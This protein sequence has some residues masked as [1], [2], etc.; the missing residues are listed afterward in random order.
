MNEP[1]FGKQKSSD[2]DESTEKKAEQDANQPT[3]DFW[4]EE[5]HKPDPTAA[6]TASPSTLP[7]SDALIKP[8]ENKTEETLTTE[9]TTTPDPAVAP[10]TQSP[11]TPPPFA[12]ETVTTAQSMPPT[13]EEIDPATPTQTETNEPNVRKIASATFRRLDE[14]LDMK[15]VEATSSIDTAPVEP[16]K[17]ETVT[18]AKHPEPMVN[19]ETPPIPT[20]TAEPVEPPT[21]ML[22]DSPIIQDEA[23][24]AETVIE[25]SAPTTKEIPMVEAT[26]EPPAPVAEEAAT[27]DV[28]IEVDELEDD[29]I[30]ADIYDSLGEETTESSPEEMGEVGMPD[31]QAGE[32]AGTTS[33]HVDVDPALVQSLIA[34]HQQ[35]LDTAGAQGRRAVFRDNLTGMDFSQQRLSG[36]SF[37]GLDLSRCKFTQALLNEV[38]FGD[39]IL[40]GADFTTANLDSATLT[41]VNANN[42][43]FSAAQM[44]KAD[45]GNAQLEQTNFT[46]AKMTEANMRD[47]NLSK[48]SLQNVTANLV[49]FRG[50]HL[51][52]ADLSEGDFSQASFREANMNDS[53]L[54]SAILI[55]TSF[56]DTE[57]M[58]VDLNSADFSQAQ[59]ISSEVQAQFMQM[60]RSKL[61]EESQ[62]LERIRNELEQ[63]ERAIISERE[64]LQRQLR[65]KGANEPAKK[66]TLDTGETATKLNKASRLFLFFGIGWFGLSFLLAIIMQNVISELDS[67]DLS[68]FEMLLMGVL[69][70][71]PLLFFV[72]SMSKSFSLSYALR[73]LTPK[74]PNDPV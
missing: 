63:R 35:W 28:S 41:N 3:M 40:Q 36:A 18:L 11:S 37:R 47:A 13:A 43:A 62:K 33:A 1:L 29:E 46:H 25:P 49:N 12:A 22:G 27:D 39:C 61:K 54:D 74:D 14:P 69:L 53:I 55:Q 2:T 5:A 72:V 66:T 56:K 58:R 68:I 24:A 42:A 45:F 26:I 31:I 15:T 19:P 50:A 44:Y 64:Q 20:P 59:D 65:S 51:F 6:P 34:E 67:G 17:E 9:P 4:G 16:P 7:A 21:A 10:P 38:D 23:P 48:A 57:L 71:M 8:F 73:K 30:S 52:K 60:E 70:L 32:L